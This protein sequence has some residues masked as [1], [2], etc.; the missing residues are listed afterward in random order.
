[1]SRP[2]EGIQQPGNDGWREVE[3]GVH[4]TSLDHLADESRFNEES[5]LK[6][7]RGGGVAIERKFA[8][9]YNT[10]EHVPKARA[11]F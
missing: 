2:I 9:Q 10:I 11:R 7:I 5:L 1:M 8:D 3:P 4:V 6:L